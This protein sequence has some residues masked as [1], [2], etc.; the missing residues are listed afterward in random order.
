MM[1]LL[2]PMLRADFT[3]L[4]GYRYRDEPPLE[5]PVTALLGQD[6]PVETAA[7]LR[8]WSEHGRPFEFRQ[9][10]GGHFFHRE[11]RDLVTDLVGGLLR[12][13]VAR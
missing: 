8:A 1:A 13:D 5:L 3:L 12:R 4:D 6:D 7:D 10:P 9:L 2:M 11:E